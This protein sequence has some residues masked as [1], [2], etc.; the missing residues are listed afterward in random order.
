MNRPESA[1]DR[2]QLAGLVFEL[3]SQLHVERAQR[4]ALQSAL[5][6]SGALDAARLEALADDPDHRRLSRAL[7]EESIARLLRVLAED[8]DPR[9]PLRGT[10]GRKLSKGAKP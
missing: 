10:P 1:P 4:I 9:R 5:E 7:L 8:R 6:R 3:A 2:R